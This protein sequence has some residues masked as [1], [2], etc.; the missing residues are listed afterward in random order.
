MTNTNLN[1]YQL[2]TMLQA[3]WYA[4]NLFWKIVPVGIQ[5]K[6]P[7]IKDWVNQASSDEAQIRE[8]WE[9]FKNANIGVATGKASGFFVIDIDIRKS[10]LQALHLLKACLHR[11]L[12][13]EDPEVLE[14]RAPEFLPDFHHVLAPVAGKKSIYSL[15]FAC[16]GSSC[17]LGIGGFKTAKGSGYGRSRELPEDHGLEQGVASQPIGPVNTHAGAFAGRIEPGHRG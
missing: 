12:L 3:I 5:S 4:V 6:K 8:W 13:A 9:H 10:P 7:L 11:L 14:H 2:A 17:G 15:L 1:K 16:H